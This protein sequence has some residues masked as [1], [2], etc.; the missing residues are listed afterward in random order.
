MYEDW[1][2]T[3]A[4]VGYDML[5]TDPYFGLQHSFGNARGGFPLWF[6]DQYKHACVGVY[7]FRAEIML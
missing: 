6:R 5:L 7:S 1:C 2:Y 4:L 3:T